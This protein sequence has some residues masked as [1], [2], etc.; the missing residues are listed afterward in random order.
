MKPSI[1]AFSYTF[2]QRLFL[3]RHYNPHD[4]VSQKAKTTQQYT[5]QPNN[6]DNASIQ[7]EEISQTTAYT[8]NLLVR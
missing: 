7:T 8:C 6:T 3:L 5:K 2:I 4:E 1:Q